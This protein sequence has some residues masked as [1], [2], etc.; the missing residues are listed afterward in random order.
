MY[1]TLLGLHS[2]L[3]YIVL[4]LLVLALLTALIGLFGKKPYSEGNRKINLFAMIFTHTQFLVGLILYFFSPMVNYSNMGEAMKDAMSR[5][6]TVEHSV[7]MLFAIILITVGHSRSKKAAEAFNK[8][9]SIALY[10]GLAVLVIVV[11]IYQSGRPL[12]GMS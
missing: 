8:H 6:W 11:A 7:M 1:N 12:L 5:Y 2:G 3:R 4:I 9:R 10:Y